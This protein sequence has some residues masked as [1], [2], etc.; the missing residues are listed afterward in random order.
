MPSLIF[1]MP[2]IID[3]RAARNLGIYRSARMEPP[4]APACHM[5]YARLIAQERV[6]RI[7]EVGHAARIAIC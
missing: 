1:D 6:S 2:L 3:L 7:D 5:A 4:M